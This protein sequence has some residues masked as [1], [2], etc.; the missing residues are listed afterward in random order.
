MEYAADLL[1]D[2]P[3]WYPLV[4]DGVHY[5]FCLESERADMGDDYKSVTRK[6]PLACWFA[7]MLTCF[8]GGLLA[9]PLCGEPVLSALLG[10]PTRIAMATALWYLVFYSPSDAVAKVLGQVGVQVRHQFSHYFFT[11]SP[12]LSKK[13]CQLESD[14][15]SHSL[16]QTYSKVPLGLVKGLYYPKKIVGGLKHSK[17]V[18]K[19]CGLC[20]IMV[21][22]IFNFT[23]PEFLCAPVYLIWILVWFQISF[24]F[25]F[26]ERVLRLSDQRKIR[27]KNL[28]YDAFKCPLR[29]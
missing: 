2:L 27:G 4:F 21:R 5:I 15:F 24:F 6:N 22:L 17:Y 25:F 18:F 8:A 3:K 14:F 10:D 19:G 28:F 26:F 12:F 7:S 20:G 9:A 1:Y 29:F 23:K 13:P 16:P 11:N